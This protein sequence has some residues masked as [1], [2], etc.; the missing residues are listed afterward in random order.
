MT[1][2]HDILRKTMNALPILLAS[3]KKIWVVCGPGEYLSPPKK[4]RLY[5][6][7]ICREKHTKKQTCK[8]PSVNGECQRW[9]TVI[10][11]QYMFSTATFSSEINNKI[12]FNYDNDEIIDETFFDEIILKE[13]IFECDEDR[14]MDG[15]KNWQRDTLNYEWRNTL[16]E[17]SSL[18]RSLDS[19]DPGVSI[20]NS[21]SPGITL[22][23]FKFSTSPFFRVKR[24]TV[25]TE[26]PEKKKNC[27][28]KD[29]KEWIITDVFPKM[30]LY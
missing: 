22:L 13:E 18:K 26:Q 16:T 17:K 19:K 4:N 24:I 12:D 11:G 2:K 3:K 21:L 15:E 7:S 27:K 5:E 1:L 25:C 10:P 29:K 6:S 14:I 9:N 20:T 28:K 8:I 30:A 23:P